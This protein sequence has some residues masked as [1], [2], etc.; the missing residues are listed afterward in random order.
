MF[1]FATETVCITTR[2]Q[3]GQ[4]V[5]TE[6]S[7]ATIHEIIR[8]LLTAERVA[9]TSKVVSERNFNNAIVLENIYDRG[10]A[11][12]VMR[13]AEAMGFVNVHMIELAEKF[14]ESQRTTAGADKWIELTKWKSTADCVKELKA[15]GKRIVVTHLGAQ[16][17]PLSEIDFSVPTALV[18]GNEKDGAS[19]EIV[20]AADDLVLLPMT[21]FVQSYNISV[22]GA[23][24]FYQI[25][26]DRMHRLGKNSDVN[27]AQIR[28]LE[29]E[30]YL[31][32]L[33]SAESI[34]IDS[35]GKK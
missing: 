30:Y 14:K 21:G 16:S 19:P 1:P 34:L 8:P 7:T 23:L 2:L 33:D 29:A 3:S 20:A 5:T 31:R 28:R 32:T 15:Q 25:F 10:N 27:E 22:A 11:S 9:K 4:K 13:T 26:Q 12:A 35:L 18:L 6:V 24:C 17:K